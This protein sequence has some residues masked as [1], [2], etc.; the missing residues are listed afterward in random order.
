MKISQWLNKTKK[1]L[2]KDK[3]LV[4]VAKIPTVWRVE[5]LRFGEREKM[6]ATGEVRC[7]GWGVRRMG[8]DV[9]VGEG[10]VERRGGREKGTKG[11]AK[12][13]G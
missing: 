1:D 11:T 8:R 6:V 5:N 2:E 9:I 4:M 10:G 12:N 7:D 3:K 13:R